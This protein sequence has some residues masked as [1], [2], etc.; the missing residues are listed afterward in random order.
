[1]N[2]PIISAIDL[3]TM[4]V[5]ENADKAIARSV[6]LAKAI[7]KLGYHRFWVPEHH[8]ISFFASASPAVLIGHIAAATRSLRIGS[9]GVMLLNILQ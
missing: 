7:E 9:G 4:R 3:V 6:E 5:G 8:G 2:I 1:M